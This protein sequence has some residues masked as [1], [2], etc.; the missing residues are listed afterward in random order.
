MQRQWTMALVT[1][2]Y[3]YVQTSVLNGCSWLEFDLCIISLLAIV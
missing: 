2:A 3:P 1:F